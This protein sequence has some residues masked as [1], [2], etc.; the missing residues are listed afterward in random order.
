MGR[1]P[2]GAAG[3]AQG[4]VFVRQPVTRGRFA[5]RAVFRHIMVPAFIFQM[6]FELWSFDR[7]SE[8][9]FHALYLA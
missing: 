2:L 6:D 3:L 8:F 1:D 9:S 5:I 4:R 7:L